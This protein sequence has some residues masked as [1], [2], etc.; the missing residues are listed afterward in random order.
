[1]TVAVEHLDGAHHHA[2]GLLE[3]V[4]MLERANGS[5]LRDHLLLDDT[6]AAD[7]LEK[8]TFLLVGVGAQHAQRIDLIEQQ[9]GDLRERCAITVGGG[10][11]GHDVRVVRGQLPLGRR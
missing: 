2:V 5:H 10:V 7:L 11:L 8:G 3:A 1:M 6:L 4:G 9:L